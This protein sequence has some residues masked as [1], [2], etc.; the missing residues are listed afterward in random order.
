MPDLTKFSEIPEVKSWL[1]GVGTELKES[2][3]GQYVMFLS[4]FLSNEDPASFLK[5]A[6][7]NPRQTA[8]EIKGRLGELYKHS[9]NAA[10]LTKYALR[11]FVE[12]HEV[13]MHVNGKIKV[14]RVRNKPELTWENANNIIQETDEP[15]RS[16]FKFM[17]WSG[18]GEDEVSE[19]QNSAE[20]Q[21]KIETQR[22]NDKPYIKIALSPRKSTLNDFFT[23][24]PKQQVPAFPMKTKVSKNRGGTLIDAHDLQNVWRRAA[25]KIKLWQ[26]G[27]GPHQLR[28]SFKSQCNRCEVAYPASE[29]CMGHGGGDRYGYGRETLDERY[30]AKELGKLWEPTKAATETEMKQV[31]ERF[32]E[33]QRFV[34]SSPAMSEALNGLPPEKRQEV[35]RIIFAE[36]STVEDIEK[37]MKELTTTKRTSRRPKQ[38]V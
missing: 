9:M 21:R 1:N 6:Q 18:L 13:E 32:K 19:I 3:R 10:H 15:Y 20:I 31:Q 33:L 16:L 8:I 35:Q 37:V 5:R 36:K 7:Q 14:R 27:L 24:V 2:T 12:F 17:L 28:S 29:F 26:V 11:S 34:V 25:K 38:Q 4:R 23:L 22:T 30:M